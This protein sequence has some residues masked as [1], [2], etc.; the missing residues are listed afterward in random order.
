MK[1]LIVIFIGVIVAF[2]LLILFA[3]WYMN[4][5]MYQMVGKKH[6]AVNW[7]LQTGEVPPLWQKRPLFSRSKISPLSI[8]PWEMKITE[9]HINNLKKLIK[10]T[11]IATLVETEAERKEVI[12]ELQNVLSNWERRR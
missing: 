2:P 10:Y 7:I 3:Y 11:N 1:S 9:N 4:F 8:K 6:E 5:M 12:R